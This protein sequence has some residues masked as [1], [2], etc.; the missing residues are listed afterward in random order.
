MV[1]GLTKLSGIEANGGLPRRI[2][3]REPSTWRPP[4]GGAPRPTHL[5]RPP[6][7]TSGSSINCK[8]SLVRPV[9]PGR[10]RSPGARNERLGG[11]LQG[12]ARRPHVRQ[13]GGGW[14]RDNLVVSLK[15]TTA[16]LPCS[17]PSD[18]DIAGTLSETTPAQSSRRVVGPYC[19][20]VCELTIRSWRPFSRH[21]TIGAV[22]GVR[23]V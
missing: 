21:A 19:H 12:W 16:L 7:S 20:W 4:C 15:R 23:P 9:A 1:R 14:P 6:V 17:S 10:P 2:L 18:A 22:T 5:G 8:G 13:R 11:R 3:A